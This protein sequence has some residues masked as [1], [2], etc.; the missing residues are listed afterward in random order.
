METAGGEGRGGIV[1]SANAL[2]SQVPTTTIL[3]GLSGKDSF[4]VLHLC[5]R[6]FGAA[7]VQAYF[8]YLVKGLRCE[9]EGP[10]RVCRQLGVEL[11]QVVHEM[12]PKLIKDGVHG[13]IPPGAKAMRSLKQG[14]VERYVS[15]KTGIPFHALGHR[16]VE[17][18]ARI[19]MLR[20]CPDGPG[21][22]LEHRKCFPIWDWKT[23][24]VFTYLRTNRIAPPSQIGTSRTGR[25]GGLSP[26]SPESMAWLRDRGGHDWT[27]WL[28]V[29]PYATVSAA[30]WDRRKVKE[31]KPKRGSVGACRP[32]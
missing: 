25:S 6:K 13:P 11:H 10:E 26:L 7:N 19:A 2:L 23:P 5:V 1:A 27:R 9:L 3:V 12:L 17:S 15:D 18:L 20:S 31:K 28:Q 30:L 16:E 8:K 22:D 14:D 29:F 32:A 21:L 4:A 24:E